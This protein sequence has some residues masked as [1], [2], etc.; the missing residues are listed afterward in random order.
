METVNVKINAK[1]EYSYPILI[2]ENLFEDPYEYI[3][4]FT[5]AERFLVVT[6]KKVNSL[7]GKYFEDDFAAFLILP[8]GEEYKNQEVLSLIIDKA[9]ALNIERQ[10]AII[11]LGGGVIG[12]MAGFAASV[13]QR[14]IDFIQVPTTLLAQV[15]SSVGGKVAVNHKSGKNLIGA[16]YQP[17]LVLADTNTLNTLDDRQYKTGLAEV[18]K[19]AFIE[20]TCGAD[21]DYKFMEFLESNKAMIFEKN[22]DVLKELI[23]ICCSL[24]SCVVNKDEKEKGLRAILNFGHTYAHAIEAITKY[25]RYTH[26]EAVSIGM[27]LIFDLA[28]NL[29]LID[30]SYYDRALKLLTDYNLC[31]NPDITFSKDAFY[32]AMKSDKKVSSG[33]INFV[34]PFSPKEVKIM[35]DIDKKLVLRGI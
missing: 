25:S 28:L 14:G 33:K 29:G 11:A 18:L 19:Y 2:G 23:K 16:F 31:I 30:K 8:D 9:I 17:K 12:D 35:N 4:Q 24:K 15:D 21:I 34:M 13:Y 5:K 26:G 10:D 3:K 22:H 27:K 7:Y 1:K 6:N 32:N 20:K